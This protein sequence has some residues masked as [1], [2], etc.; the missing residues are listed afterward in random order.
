MITKWSCEWYEYYSGKDDNVDTDQTLRVDEIKNI[1]SNDWKRSRRWNILTIV[2]N[3]LI[4]SA[5][6][7]GYHCAV[8][9]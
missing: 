7:F 9:Y 3:D 6:G 8:D 2:S 5:N 1:I 4:T